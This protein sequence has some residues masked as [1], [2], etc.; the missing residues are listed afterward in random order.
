MTPLDWVIAALALWRLASLFT[1]ER[2][3]FDVFWRLR[4]RA[5]IIHDDEGRP[6]G[7]DETRYAAGLLYC[8]WCFSLV[9]ALLY[10][11]LWLVWPDGA[12]ALSV[13]FAL[14]AGAIAAGRY[15]NGKG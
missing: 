4:A 2:G 12:R 1:E 13:P 10:G 11:A 6:I 5:G 15:I 9:A 7:Y 8:L 3:P 14:S